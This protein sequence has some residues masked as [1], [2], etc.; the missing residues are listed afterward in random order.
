VDVDGTSVY[1]IGAIRRKRA[2]R[3]KSNSISRL[4]DERSSPGGM[5][6]VNTL[7]RTDD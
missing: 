5:E 7:G 3:P 2:R 6:G 4:L 1:A